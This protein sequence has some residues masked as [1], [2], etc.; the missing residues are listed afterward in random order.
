MV[1]W[2]MAG[3]GATMSSAMGCGT[4]LDFVAVFAGSCTCNKRRVEMKVYWGLWK[5][6]CIMQP[7]V[8]CPRLG[9]GF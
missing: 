6:V 7:D 2:S 4:F 9:Q 8:L 3:Q 5:A 1:L